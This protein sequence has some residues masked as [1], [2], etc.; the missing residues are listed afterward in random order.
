MWSKEIL[1][2]FL[3]QQCDLD[4]QV[5]KVSEIFLRVNNIKDCS[6]DNF[7]TWEFIKEETV[8]HAYFADYSTY[9]A[10]QHEIE[11]PVE[12]LW[13]SPEEINN[14]EILNNLGYYN[15]MIKMITELNKN[16]EKVDIAD[17]L[18]LKKQIFYKLKK[19]LGL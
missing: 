15:D 14:M 11:F 3:N 16:P 9:D 1:N 4:I 19:E 7:N 5:K 17:S 6:I 13:N 2:N 10:K 8:I 12:Y 18:L